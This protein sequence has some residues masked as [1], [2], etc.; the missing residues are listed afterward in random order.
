LG[1]KDDLSGLNPYKKFLGQ[2]I[3][4]FTVAVFGDYRISSFYGIFGISEL[5]YWV[6]I[7]FTIFV[8]LVII[9]GFNLI[10]GIDGLAVSIGILS[11]LF[12]GMWFFNIPEPNQYYIVAIALAGA[13]V[14]FLRINISPDKMFMGDTGSMFLGYIAAFLAI[15]F[16]EKHSEVCPF[17][18]IQSSPVLAMAIIF[19]PIYDT[20]R[21][22]FVRIVKGKNPFKPD[23]NHVH[24]LL[25]RLGFTHLQATITLVIYSLSVIFLTLWLTKIKMGY[26]L[27]FGI[28]LLYS[29]ILNTI[30]Y[31]LVKKK[32]ANEV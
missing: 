19:L 26:L 8:F 2:I 32:E 28:I 16:I 11:S 12:F 13:A 18:N 9:N 4:A 3:A 21:S 7:L 23:K 15:V 30:L 1:I 22:F 24:H 5:P 20:T 27:T 10:D 14:S 25:I 29:I 6:S 31:S 17:F